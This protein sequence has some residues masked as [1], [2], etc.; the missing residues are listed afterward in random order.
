[1]VSYWTPADGYATMRGLGPLPA[2]AAVITDPWPE[3]ARGADGL[4][5]L[6]A[7]LTDSDRAFTAAPLTSAEFWSGWR[8]AAALQSG[9]PLILE[10]TRKQLEA[11]VTTS[12]PRLT[13]QLA[14]LYVER[15][16]TATEYPLANPELDGGTPGAAM[17]GLGAVF[18]LSVQQVL[19]L[20]LRRSVTIN[21]ALCPLTSPVPS[22]AAEMAALREEVDS[23]AAI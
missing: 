10:W 19:D 6:A 11:A 17:F 22:D 13:A 16:E 2:G 21:R 4:Y 12:P 3:I 7:D 9:E 23:L 1:G 18:G 14:P 8:A 5:K 20:F 15:M